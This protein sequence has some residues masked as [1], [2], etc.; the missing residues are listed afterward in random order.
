MYSNFSRQMK[1]EY[2]LA[3]ISRLYQEAKL[4]EERKAKRG[5][6]FNIF[7]V[8]GLSSEEVRLHSAFIAELLNPQGS[9]GVG[10]LFLKEFLK[11]LDLPIDYIDIRYFSQDK[12][13]ER[14]RVTCKTLC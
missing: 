9:H 1:V 11:L 14:N 7:N 3:Q 2:L 8:I 6:F 4:D 10:N 13:T 5:E 12:I